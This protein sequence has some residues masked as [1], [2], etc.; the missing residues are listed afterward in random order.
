[1]GFPFCLTSAV[2]VQGVWVGGWVGGGSYFR[3][4]ASSSIGQ[5]N[6]L[7]APLFSQRGLHLPF[8]QACPFSDI[9]WLPDLAMTEGPAT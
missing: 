7:A 3:L 8:E 6:R 5:P 9:L 2:L 1:M 4:P